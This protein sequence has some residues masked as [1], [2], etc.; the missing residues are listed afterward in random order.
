MA[1][2]FLRLII[3]RLGIFFLWLWPACRL[4][5][6][7]L[8]HFECAD[9]LA[10]RLDAL[11]SD[12]FLHVYLHGRFALVRTAEHHLEARI[13]IVA[14]EQ[15]AALRVLAYEAYLLCRR[16]HDESLDVT[17]ALL[18]G[19]HKRDCPHL[20][21]V[22]LLYLEQILVKVVRQ[23]EVCRVILALLCNNEYLVVR[24][25]FAEEVAVAVVVEPHHVR[26]IPNL[27]AAEC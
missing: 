18:V 26:V 19:V 10:L 12:E 16:L 7:N 6:Y 21:W 14:D 11:D 27:P 24:S 25:E 4:Q 3:I 20:L 22:V 1:I 23:V 15:Q 13:H 17:V 2:L 8:A 9:S 5:F